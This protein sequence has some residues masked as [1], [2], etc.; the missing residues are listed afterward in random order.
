MDKKT[1]NRIGD[2]DDVC[3]M[4]GE[5]ISPFGLR[6]LHVQLETANNNARARF[7]LKWNVLFS[8]TAP[9]A[10]DDE[11][12]G[13]NGSSSILLLFPCPDSNWS[14]PESLVCDGRINCPQQSVFGYLL[15]EELCTTSNSSYN[16]DYYYPCVMVLVGYNHPKLLDVLQDKE[17]IRTY[18]FKQVPFFKLF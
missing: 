13:A 1:N 9:A 14:I 7:L 5:F 16:Q 18:V 12:T 6:Y 2:D 3:S 11:L 15:G 10:V 17:N 8:S 4:N